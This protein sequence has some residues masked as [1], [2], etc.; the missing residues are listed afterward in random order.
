M[1][2]WIVKLV[3]RSTIQ[4]LLVNNMRLT[5]FCILETLLFRNMDALGNGSYF[6]HLFSSTFYIVLY[7]PD[8]KICHKNMFES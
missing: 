7:F 5:V 3:Y 8:K 4:I 6:S 2:K 1:L